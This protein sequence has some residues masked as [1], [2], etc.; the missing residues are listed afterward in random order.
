MYILV[1]IG[2]S[3]ERGWGHLFIPI[4]IYDSGD[5]NSPY[6]LLALVIDEFPT[7]L[8]GTGPHC[9]LRLSSCA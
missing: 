4:P 8:G 7:G 5:Q 6:L 9:H 3:G 1:H 2:V